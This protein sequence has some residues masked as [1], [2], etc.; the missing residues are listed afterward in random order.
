MF[1]G[2]CFSPVFNIKDL[3]NN[4]T[5]FLSYKNSDKNI[6]SE[7]KKQA[8]KEFDQDVI[9]FIFMDFIRSISIL[10]LSKLGLMYSSLK[11]I[12]QEYKSPIWSEIFNKGAKTPKDYILLYNV[13]DLLDKTRGALNSQA[14]LE[15][16]F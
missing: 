7:H 10:S 12:T 2:G 11:T 6:K 15:K 14:K 16:L 9:D 3:R 5:I 4:N 13:A 1:I 8:N